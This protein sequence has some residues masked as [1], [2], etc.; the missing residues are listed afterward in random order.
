MFQGYVGKCLDTRFDL[1]VGCLVGGSVSPRIE[2]VNYI[3]KNWIISPI[4]GWNCLKEI[5]K[6]TYM[7]YMEVM[8]VPPPIEAMI[9]IS[10]ITYVA[11]ISPAKKHPNPLV[12]KNKKAPKNPS[13]CQR[14]R[15]HLE[16]QKIEDGIG[17]F[18]LVGGFNPF[19]KNMLINLDHFP[20]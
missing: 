14:K 15:L 20:N 17:I 9:S 11:I 12:K 3:V 8:F 10:M 13:T 1:V 4:C 2:Q 6:T 5:F 7:I 18:S 19:E 16:S